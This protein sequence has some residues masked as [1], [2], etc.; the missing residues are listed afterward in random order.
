MANANKIM[1]HE[2]WAQMKTAKEAFGTCPFCSDKQ[3][4]E[5]KKDPERMLVVCQDCS[6]KDGNDGVEA[7][8]SGSHGCTVC[9]FHVGKGIT[10]NALR[11][12]VRPAPLS[13]AAKPP[14]V[15]TR[16]VGGRADGIIK[17]AAAGENRLR[18]APSAIS[19]E[20]L[21]RFR[22]DRTHRHRTRS[23]KLLTARTGS[24]RAALQTCGTPRALG[25]ADLVAVSGRDAPDALP[26]EGA[27]RLA[28]D[29]THASASMPI[30]YAESYDAIFF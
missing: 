19:H 27:V 6:P 3:N 9:R 5:G 24:Y 23:M 25:A 28:S 15:G 7:K 29:R 12:G 13:H 10:T 14:R 4:R 21:V 26:H 22:L 2:C 30:P 18:R 11:W 17:T 8:D 16:R 20:G 1:Q